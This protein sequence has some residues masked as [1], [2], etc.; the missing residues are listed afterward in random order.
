MK[1]VVN[2]FIQPVNTA[3]LLHNFFFIYAIFWNLLLLSLYFT[4][5][6]F[7]FLLIFGISKISIFLEIIGIF[8][9][10]VPSVFILASI[11]I[12]SLI[13][14]GSIIFVALII[15]EIHLLCLLKW[16]FTVLILN[17]WT[18]GNSLCTS[19]D[20]SLW[21]N[22][23]ARLISFHYSLIWA[24]MNGCIVSLSLLVHGIINRSSFIKRSGVGG[25]ILLKTSIGRIFIW[26]S[27]YLVRK[28]RVYIVLKASFVVFEHSN[29]KINY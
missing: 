17:L 14:C 2:L 16:L 11:F 10:I 29:V 12:I 25:G 8:L 21:I 4:R 7:K 18:V 26:V 6:R 13:I 27:F 28:L 15:A 23:W 19:F 9:A 3:N 20:H 5:L 22:S 1:P 24:L